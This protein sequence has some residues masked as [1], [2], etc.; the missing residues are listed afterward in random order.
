MN[1][2]QNNPAEMNKVNASLFD[3]EHFRNYCQLLKYPARN[4]DKIQAIEQDYPEYCSL[5]IGQVSDLLKAAE[6]AE[7][8]ASIP[9]MILE[10]VD[11]LLRQLNKSCED[12]V[13]KKYGALTDRP[14]YICEVCFPDI[15][16]ATFL[17][18]WRE[19]THIWGEDSVDFREL[20]DKVIFTITL[21]EEDVMNN[22]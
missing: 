5:T 10:D 7:L 1:N 13:C 17:T 4:A 2:T 8:K 18:I 16:R 3:L 19:F 21:T 20:V 14:V 9:S 11:T 22:L 12:S 15:S 6:Q